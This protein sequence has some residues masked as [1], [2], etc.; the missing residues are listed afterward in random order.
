MPEDEAVGSTSSIE[1]R[2][3]E[4]HEKAVKRL[5]E[6]HQQLEEPLLLALSYDGD[7]PI[8]VHLLEVLEKFP[9]ADDDELFSTTYESS[10]SLRILGKLHLTLG[11]PAQ[12]RAAVRRGD[13]LI[14]KLAGAQVV[15]V[16]RSKSEAEQLLDE[17]GLH[18]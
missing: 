11:S 1:Q 18:P 3:H 8:D 16:D 6:A 5:V 10:A 14:G 4:L 17:L 7:D 2:V 15:F 12:L 9:G 13:P